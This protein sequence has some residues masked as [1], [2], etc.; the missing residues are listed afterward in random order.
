VPPLSATLIAR[1]GVVADPRWSPDGRRLGW[2]QGDLGRFDL[3]VAGAPG[4]ADR[5]P[6]VLTAETGVAPTQSTG[7]GCWC[8]VGPDH[9]AV[10]D[11]LS[12]LVLVPV[13]GRT[14]RTLA[15]DGRAA[16]PAATADGQR[17][18]YVLE[19]DDAC[20]VAVVD[21]EPPSWP[22]QVSHTDFAWDPAWA[23]DGSRLAWH[24]WDLDAMS[25]DSSRI[26]VADGAGTAKVVAGGD[27]V[28][29]GQPRFSPSGD[30][31][32]WVSDEHGW[33]NVTVA[34]LDGA[35]ATP[36]VAEPFEHAEPAWGLGQRSYAWSPDGREVAVCR[37]EDG[38]GRL[39]ATRIAT[40]DVRDLARGWHHGLDW[41]RGGIVAVRSGARTPPNVCIT[42]PAPDSSAAA[43]R[44]VVAHAA[45]AGVRRADLVE[46]EPV[47]W[48]GDDGAI[49]YG[50]LF[51]PRGADAGASPLLV[52]VHGGPTGQATVQWKPSHQYFLTRGFAVLA[53]DPRGSTGHGRAYTQSL[54]GRWGEL[55]VS[56]CVAGIRAAVERGWCDP[57]RIVASGA[58]SGG[59]TA[60][61]LA[62]R[63]PDLLR[64]VVTM[65]AVT[66]LQELAAT[67]H[68][69]ESRSLDR[70]VGVLPR[71]LATYRERSPITHAGELRVPTL[72]LHGDAD[73]VVPPQQAVALVDAVRAA[74]GTIE[75]HMYADEGHGWS[76]PDTVLDVYARLDAF[77]GRHCGPA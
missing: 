66:D 55:D 60:L 43:H 8:W 61:L 3:L 20:D 56:D 71:D 64:A 29:V 23:P 21:L 15:R 38:F 34:D 35:G 67:T 12:H 68:R 47:T 73:N 52:D 65:Y 41:G 76:R 28:S 69:F 2:I 49:V 27:D 75:H 44:E 25:W 58:S 36:V 5:A 51:R 18:A 16:A 53:P 11:A 1:T 45:P 4:V 62:V 50:L 57:T 72:V 77:L 31:L 30:A 40:G 7:G 48:H 17:I 33:W 10:V 24:E 63:E 42:T 54:S 59:M 13:D 6:T 22:R 9:V 26:V 19:R 39:V 46:P 14:P 70:L 32:A 37:N 74:G